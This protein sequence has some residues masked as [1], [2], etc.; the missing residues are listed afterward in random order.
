MT[1]WTSLIIHHSH[2]FIW[3]QDYNPKPKS[4]LSSVTSNPS[5]PS[6][7]LTLVSLQVN[8]HHGADDEAPLINHHDACRICRI[9]SFV[10]MFSSGCPLVLLSSLPSLSISCVVFLLHPNELVEAPLSSLSSWVALLLSDDAF[11]FW[12]ILASFLSVLRSC[13]L[14]LRCLHLIAYFF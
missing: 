11:L 9:R 8:L 6:L 14:G 4:E 13:H 5:N 12:F 10:M 1:W 3:P 7:D 2:S